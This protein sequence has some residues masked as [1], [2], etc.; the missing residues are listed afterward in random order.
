[1]EK[2]AKEGME[3]RF[4]QINWETA[5]HKKE[6]Y[7]KRLKYEIDVI[8]KMGFPGYFLIVS[9]F[10]QWSKH[11]GVAVGAGRGSGAGSLVAWC[12]KITEVDPLEYGLFFER[13]L[14]PER[15]SMPD[16][17]IDFCQENRWK[18]IEYVMN[19]YG[20]ESVARIITYGKM[21]AKMVIKDVGRVMQMSFNETNEIVKLIP[22]NPLEPITIEKALEMIP[23]LK[24][25]KEEELRKQKERERIAFLSCKTNN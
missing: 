23:K 3:E 6:D 14:N 9:D 18:T 17:D 13:F 22:F 12:L 11:N 15:V 7:W 24:E 8:K 1:M 19:K 20:K 16:F 4:Y 25:A 10:V 5:I 2:L 21:K